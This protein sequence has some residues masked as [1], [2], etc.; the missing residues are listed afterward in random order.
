MIQRITHKAAQI[1]AG[2][3]TRKRLKKQLKQSFTKMTLIELYRSYEEEEKAG[4][5]NGASHDFFEQTNWFYANAEFDPKT[6]EALPQALSTF[7]YKITKP[8]DDGIIHDRLWRITNHAR[9]SVER[10]FHSLNESPRREQALLPVRAVRELDVNSFIKLSNR[11]GRNIRE[12][13]A[14]KP[15]LYA[16]HRFQS[17]DLPENRLLKE[18]VTRLAKL[19]ELRYDCLKE[20]EEDELLPKINSWLLGDEAQSISRWENLPP[21]NTLL[22]HRDYRRIWDAWRWLQTLDDDI[23]KDLLDFKARRKTMYRWRYEYGQKY[24]DR[25]FLFADMPVCFDYEKFEINP[26]EIP[27]FQ[28]RKKEIVRHFTKEEISEP[29]CVDF[30]TLRPRYSTVKDVSQEL[31][32]TYLWQHWENNKDK[33]FDLELFNSDAAFLHPDVKA[34]ISSA[35]LFFSKDKQIE[36]LD[37][38]ARAFTL[39]LHKTF[40]NDTLIWLVPDFLNDFEL[41]LT[42]RNINA[43]FPKAEPLPRSVAAVFENVDFSSIK[44]EGFTVVVVDT[45]GGKTCATKL[46]ARFDHELINRI[47]ETSGYYW[48]RCPP[49]PIEHDAPDGTEIKNYEIITVDEKGEWQNEV[50]PTAPEFIEPATLEKNQRIGQFAILINLSESPVAGGARLHDLQQRAGNIPL[51]RDHIPELKIKVMINGSYQDYFLVSR[52]LKPIKPIRDV[53]VKIEIND[54]FTL[55]GGK[56][57]YQFP[58]FQG[59]NA[60]EVGYSAKLESPEFPLNEDIV[61]DLNLTFTYGADDPYCLVFK[62]QNKEFPPV[63]AKWER[64]GEKEITDAPAPPYPEP[65]SWE[66]LRYRPKPDGS[67]TSKLFEWIK[68]AIDNFQPQKR[69]IGIIKKPWD[70]DINNAR[71]ITVECG[72]NNLPVRIYENNFEPGFNYQDIQLGGKVS[73]ELR[74]NH[75]KFN[76]KNAINA[77]FDASYFTRI[78]HKRLY[79]PFIEIWKDGRSISDKECPQEFANDVKNRIIYLD[80]L[81]NQAEL[82]KSVKN[83]L[84]FLLACVHRD[85]TEKC[86]NW[87]IEEVD[88]P[89]LIKNS[90]AIGFALGDVSQ[91]WQQNVLLKLKSDPTEKAIRIFAYAIWHEQNFINN[92]TITELNSILNVLKEMLSQVKP[93]PQNEKDKWTVRNWVRSTAEPL[94][95]LLGL[96]RTRESSDPEIKMLLQPNR[97]ITKE[98]AKQVENIIRIFTE[99][100][101]ELYSRVQLID[102]QKPKNF[103]IPDLLYALRLYLTGDDGANAI[104]I[105]GVSD[106]ENN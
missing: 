104:R 48:E 49:V 69:T 31:Y 72:E 55:P 86:I 43:R 83:E 75:G 6:N 58:L 5:K 74:E 8:A 68:S 62:P 11:P 26:W 29:V 42:R 70:K 56:P 99:T 39:K 33:P 7:L 51:W 91:G 21:N 34:A 73:F 53:A 41:E 94:E 32:E 44:G 101:A 59:E 2:K 98:M 15:Y 17:V 40:T 65:L 85:T 100:K 35:D 22:S 92:F 78:I 105:T 82:P 19:L 37:S 10:V 60:D 61:C 45:I 46:I 47:S 66:D 30:T 88:N 3:N 79:Y 25:H 64:K 93:C 24:S 54:T 106:N 13:L 96:L 87:I 103:F 80:S 76:G 16:V 90:R 4:K 57:F 63:K 14:S 52:E 36:H 97:K 38:A 28:K 9:D 50:K 18:F 71:F 67:G 12:K 81:L 27:V 20:K 1:K 89:P 95:F 84:L 23:N 102:L 77:I